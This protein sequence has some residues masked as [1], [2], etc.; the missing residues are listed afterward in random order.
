MSKFRVMVWL[1]ISLAWRYLMGARRD[2]VFSIMAV[3]AFM[4]AVIGVGALIVGM[5]ITQ[6]VKV[7]AEDVLLNGEAHIWILPS[8]DE[9][10]QHQEVINFREFGISSE[11]AS[12]L[13]ITAPQSIASRSL[14][15][16]DS[17]LDSKLNSLDGV[18]HV[19]PSIDSQVIVALDADF[20]MAGLSG[21]ILDD[22]ANSKFGIET[23]IEMADWPLIVPDSLVR[24][25]RISVGQTVV[26]YSS[27]L[28]RT[29]IGS[30]PSSQGFEVVGTYP[31]TI[32]DDF[33]TSIKAAQLFLNE[34][35]RV[36]SVEIYLKDPS[37]VGRMVGDLTELFGEFEV[38]SRRENR[39]GISAFLE[40][41]RLVML[42]TL[43][44]ILLVSAFNIFASQLMLTN[45]QRR[46]IGVMRS[47]GFSRF[48]I[49]RIF[50]LSG[51]L[52]GFIGASFGTISGLVFALNFPFIS[53]LGV[54]GL[55]FF[56]NSPPII[57][58]KDVSVAFSLCIFM[59]AVASI[60]P[61]WLVASTSPIE[62]FSHG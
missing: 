34:I 22:V 36:S 24:S 37:E 48:S 60:F 55:S 10:T 39:E 42:V 50:F 57:L 7:N 21:V 17:I 27:K 44:L 53:A 32:R 16:L 38:Q 56:S 8:L 6:G 1:E 45:A 23:S 25:G 58:L 12:A 20:A 49:I 9:G 46:S 18:Q 51:F 5:A 41:L 43:G 61:A 11:D 14:I 28:Q 3:L 33:Y 30:L 2:G 52:V 40:V 31:G 59:T 4:G 62:A 54:P 29:P 26:L 19:R 47:T 15:F 35:G 13:G